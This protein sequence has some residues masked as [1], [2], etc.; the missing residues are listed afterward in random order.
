VGAHVY[1]AKLFAGILA[2]SEVFLEK[3]KAHLRSNYGPIDVESAVFPFRFTTYYN[4]EM[5]EG[6]LRQYVSFADL[7][8]PGRLRRIKRETI[9]LESEMSENGRRKAN[10]DPGYLNL[11]TVV[12]ATTKDA[13]HRVYL[14]D[15]IFGHTTFSYV[16]GE[17]VP[18]D[19]AYRDYREPESLEFFR[20]VRE[21][22]KEQLAE[23][24]F[25]KEGG[26]RGPEI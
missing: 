7:I 22:C 4:A 15:G 11:S 1:R 3:A 25:R 10:V 19:W 6:I 9:E 20:N 14:G 12:L 24:A 18:F 26:A 13:S 16:R 2:S 8:D 23:R 5:G 21:K 17:F